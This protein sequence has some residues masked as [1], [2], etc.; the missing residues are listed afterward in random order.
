MITPEEA[1]QKFRDA[2]ICISKW[3]AE[4]GLSKTAVDAVLYRGSP[5]RRGDTHKAAI[6]LG[7]K[8]GVAGSNDFSLRTE[9]IK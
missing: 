8:D 1:R 2:G 9:S 6:A 5:G 3:A 4:K 7:I